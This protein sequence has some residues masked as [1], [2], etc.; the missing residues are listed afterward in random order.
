MTDPHPAVGLNAWL[1]RTLSHGEALCKPGRATQVAATALATRTPTAG[2]PG[3]MV[4]AV[5]IRQP[6]PALAGGLAVASA[7]STAEL[8]EAQKSNRPENGPR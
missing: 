5:T 2:R 6:Q 4:F 1:G 3:P 7:H 8:A